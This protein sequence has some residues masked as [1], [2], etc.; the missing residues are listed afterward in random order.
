MFF[1]TNREVPSWVQLRSETR[2]KR[3]ET[4][5]QLTIALKGDEK[6]DRSDSAEPVPPEGNESSAF[7]WVNREVPPRVRLRCEMLGLRLCIS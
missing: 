5:F 3:Y 2:D 7:C 6:L 4:A 1:G